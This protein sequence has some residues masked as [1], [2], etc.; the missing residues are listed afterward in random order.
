MKHICEYG[1]GKEAIH[2]FKN[3]NWCCS[4]TTQSCSQKRKEQSEK[5][6]G[7]NSKRY[8]IKSSKET[9]MKISKAVS[10][11]NN[12]MWKRDFS[13]EHRRKLGLVNKGKS[14]IISKEHK[15]KLRQARLYSIEDWYEKYPILKKVEQFR[16]NPNNLDEIQAHCK[17]H[18][19]S[20]SKEKGGWFTPTRQQLRDRIMA[21][22]AFDGSYLYCSNECKNECPLFNVY[23]DP[24]RNIS[25]PYTNE[26]YQIW[27][28]EVLNRS[29]YKCEYCNEA[30]T[31][32]HHSRPQKLEPFYS[33]DPDFGIACCEKCHYEKGHK[34]ECSTGNLA[35]INC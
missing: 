18:N 4:K 23:S 30:A 15:N 19:C 9:R 5:Q 2:Q 12:P 32:V 28:L 14:K 29:E 27:R 25:K 7:E 16:Y 10:G 1:C 8:G 20:N 13:N 34:D 33:L 17:N 6:S 26:E 35:T 24:N 31:H 11:K 21:T 22:T 3:G